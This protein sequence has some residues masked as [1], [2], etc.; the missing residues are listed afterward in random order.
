MKKQA[1]VENKGVK[2]AVAQRKV[3]V[4]VRPFRAVA[5]IGGPGTEAEVDEALAVELASIGYVE[6]LKEREQ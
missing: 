4:R 6:I 1:D 2:A 3:K 5:G